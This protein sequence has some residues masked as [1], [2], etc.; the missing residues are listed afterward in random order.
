[1]N[2]KIKS[3]V[4]ALALKW[5]EEG[6]V[7]CDEISEV[8]KLCL[9]NENFLPN[10]KK[11]ID[12]VINAYKRELV[13]IDDIDDLFS[14]QY[15]KASS[16]KE[17]K[18]LK[19]LIS[20]GNLKLVCNDPFY[21]S[22]E[23]QHLDSLFEE[24][25]RKYEET[26]L[27]KIK[28]YN[29]EKVLIWFDS[30]KDQLDDK[31]LKVIE[32]ELSVLKENKLR[33]LN[34]LIPRCSITSYSLVKKEFMIAEKALGQIKEIKNKE[35]ICLE[36]E[37][38]NARDLFH[39]YYKSYLERGAASRGNEFDMALINDLLLKFPQ[40]SKLKL[41][42]RNEWE[43]EVQARD[44]LEK[45][46][47]QKRDIEIIKKHLN[48]L[49]IDKAD[50]CFDDLPFPKLFMNEYKEYYENAKFEIIKIKL[51]DLDRKSAKN[52]FLNSKFKLSNTRYDKLFDKFEQQIKKKE[53]IEDLIKMDRYKEAFHLNYNE[54]IKEENISVDCSP[55]LSKDLFGNNYVKKPLEKLINSR[56][57]KKYE[58]D[59]DQA[60]AVCSSMK[61]TL[62]SARAGSGK[63]RILISR[64]L[65]LFNAYKYSPKNILLLVFNKS[66]RHDIKK[67]LIYNFNW[68][69]ASV[70]ECVHSFHSFAYLIQEK[71]FSDKPDNAPNLLFEETEIS[72]IIAELFDEKLNS[73]D[74]YNQKFLEFIF[75]N[76]SMV[77]T[78][79]D[80][81]S[82][83]TSEDYFQ[84]LRN[85]R[86][87][88][89]DNKEVK[90]KGEK[91]IAD[92][93]F[94]HGVGYE[95]EKSIRIIS[96][97]K[98]YSPD[99]C[100][101]KKADDERVFWGGIDKEI[102]WEHWGVNEGKPIEEAHWKI[103]P[104]QYIKEM[105]IKRDYWRARQNNS[106]LIES[107]ISDINYGAKNE[108][109][110]FEG[111]IKKK[112][113]K[114]GIFPTKLSTNEIEKR[115]RAI[116][117]K[118]LID[119]IKNF[120][121]RMQSSGMNLK[122][123]N[124]KIQ[125]NTFE[126][127]Q[128]VF[129]FLATKLYEEFNV[130]KRQTNQMDF[131]DLLNF[132]KK[133]INEGKSDKISSKILDIKSILIDEFQDFNNQFSKIIKSIQ[134]KNND[135]DIFCVGDDWQSINSFMGSNLNHFKNFKIN[136]IDSGQLYVN[137]N[138]RSSRA[139]VDYGNRIMEG[140]GEIAIPKK[141]HRGLIEEIYIESNSKFE[142]SGADRKFAVFSQK[143]S[144]ERNLNAQYDPGYIKARY[145]RE[146]FNIALEQKKHR[147]IL[148]LARNNNF[149]GSKIIEFEDNLRRLLR[150]QKRNDL[151]INISTTHKMKGGEASVVVLMGANSNFYPSI[152][153]TAKY[154]SI[155]DDAPAEF[156][157]NHIDEERRLFY[158][159]ATRAKDKLYLICK[160]IQF[161]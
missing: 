159:A 60:I 66:V 63:T 59:S 139:V 22:L 135:T 20:K 104:K 96:T 89:L 157:K 87:R 41:T 8:F 83:D 6:S 110:E 153:P 68:D 142:Y 34:E 128:D 155:F 107:S 77:D 67:R 58:L 21:L 65:M 144:A 126:Y 140:L 148:I 48:N 151:A 69:E 116:W 117:R 92:F 109:L 52:E 28:S 156:M 121:S 5:T 150:K 19:T 143:K 138:Y 18:R 136:N 114:I 98:V 115:L 76:K 133:A 1:M 82:F 53:Q 108:R 25:Q 54:F 24:K 129:F 10:E 70:N 78:K 33:E 57:N 158:V 132:A 40:L 35:V 71:Y 113:E 56:S 51:K 9:I 131:S 105:N 17:I 3:C 44:K 15:S 125:A 161:N 36:F 97:G 101:Y 85:M 99:F 147:D 102:Y 137:N 152:H 64:L 130:Y 122:S 27:I 62:V 72:K 141:Q 111:I 90:S 100:I 31:T 81:T 123:L 134:L 149:R 55:I 38:N 11:I 154:F 103:S 146:L 93:L 45:L 118:P 43:K 49:D 39:Y 94:E 79:F 74:L 75:L 4:R 95:Y 16:D 7:S 30:I 73:D 37:K 112:L 61:S 47:R 14:I 106:I 160:N 119:S 12:P 42:I 120:I 127:D 86:Y 50:L 32:E 46:Q 124:K 26:V 91:Y 84:Y 88:T 80:Q 2:N 29:L 145:L 23:N 13:T